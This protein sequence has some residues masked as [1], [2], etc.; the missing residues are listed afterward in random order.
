MKKEKR[1]LGILLVSVVFGLLLTS[2]GTAQPAPQPFEPLAEV[3]E[4]VD[5]QAAGIERITA[6]AHTTQIP[7]REFAVV[8]AVSLRDVNEATLLADL[9]DRAIQM[10]GHDIINI[11]VGRVVETVIIETDE[12]TERQTQRRIS[13][14]T[15]VVIRYTDARFY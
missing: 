13:N 4:T 11:R 5:V 14:A 3:T 7:N 1:T 10:G 8:G 12:R 2:C 6:W 9:M 15:A